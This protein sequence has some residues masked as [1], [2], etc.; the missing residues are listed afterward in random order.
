MASRHD[1]PNGS[2]AIDRGDRS[3]YLAGIRS[4]SRSVTPAILCSSAVICTAFF[5]GCPAIACPFVERS[6]YIMAARTVIA[7][8]GFALDFT[9]AIRLR[10]AQA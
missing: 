2:L 4:R 6:H 10:I 5:I 1:V 9:T 7:E 8:L 3:A